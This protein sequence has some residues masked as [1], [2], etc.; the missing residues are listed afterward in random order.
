MKDKIYTWKV[1]R[2]I[3]G[4]YVKYVSPYTSMWADWYGGKWGSLI[5][6]YIPYQ[7]TFSPSSRGL[8]CWKT[9]SDARILKRI[10]SD[11]VIFK[12]EINTEDVLHKDSDTIECKRLVV[13]PIKG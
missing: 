6:E 12:V 13:L 2:K 10:Y 3:K 4:K 5:C 1:V 8:Y 11:F 7:P 9:R